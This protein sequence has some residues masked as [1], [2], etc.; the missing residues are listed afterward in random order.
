LAFRASLNNYD[1]G[2]FAGLPLVTHVA[3]EILVRR[4]HDAVLCNFT[5]VRRFWAVSRFINLDIDVQV[6]R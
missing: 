4:E 1:I 2:T 5:V 6:I 3:R